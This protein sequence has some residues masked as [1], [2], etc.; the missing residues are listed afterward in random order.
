MP[1]KTGTKDAKCVIWVIGEFLVFTA[2]TG[3]NDVGHV[4]WALGEF[5]FCILFF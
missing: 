5:F 4:V 3:P 2:R 1:A